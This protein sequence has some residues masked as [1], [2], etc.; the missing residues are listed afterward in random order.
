MTVAF[1]RWHAADVR[2]ILAAGAG[3]AHP[4]PAGNALTVELPQVATRPLT[5]Y[6]IG[7]LS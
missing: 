6:A 3:I 1:S 2:A 4:K 5:D 7:S